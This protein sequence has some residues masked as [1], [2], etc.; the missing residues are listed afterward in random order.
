MSLELYIS[1]WFIVFRG[2]WLCTVPWQNQG[3]PTD[4]ITFYGS[5]QFLI[6]FNGKI[7]EI[8]LKTWE[9]SRRWVCWFLIDWCTNLQNLD[10][11][12]NFTQCALVT[13][14]FSWNICPVKSLL[15]YQEILAWVLTKTSRAAAELFRTFWILGC[16]VNTL[17]N[18]ASW[19]L[20]GGSTWWLEDP[21]IRCR[22]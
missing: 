6:T 15:S 8:L 4:S 12:P 1:S 16:V 2:N 9:K 5:K 13:L 22:S 21:P 7:D 20:R 11:D 17:D 18:F 10:L 3:P 14:T 19:C